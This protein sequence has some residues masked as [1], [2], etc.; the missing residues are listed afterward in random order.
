MAA[1]A[2]RS[3][4]KKHA[5]FYSHPPLLL[6]W[7][8]IRFPDSCTQLQQRSETSRGNWGRVG[9]RTSGSSI[10]AEHTGLSTDF[11]GFLWVFGKCKQS[12]H[13][14][15][16]STGTGEGVPLHSHPQP[17]S[18]ITVLNQPCWAPPTPSPALV[19]LEEVCKFE[20]GKFPPAF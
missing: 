5:I 8:Q 16:L 2:K 1:R 7:A 15:R 4:F 10:S 13:G 18:T 12:R 9:G 19:H 6:P 3:R 14:R 17:V 11:P 20:A